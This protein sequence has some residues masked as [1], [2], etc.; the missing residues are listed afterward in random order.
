M[1][2]MCAL[3][4]DVCAVCVLGD[5]RNAFFCAA[6]VVCLL[7]VCR[8]KELGELTAI[9]KK[10]TQQWKASISD[11]TGDGCGKN[12]GSAYSTLHIRVPFV[13]VCVCVCVCA[14][15]WCLRSVWLKRQF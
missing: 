7:V 15:G 5:L 4:G 14:N 12:T 11:C 1:Y 8:T 3:L 13:I 10:K 2:A 6:C 9:L